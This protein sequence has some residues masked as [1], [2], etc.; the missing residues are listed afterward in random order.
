MQVRHVLRAANASL[1]VEIPPG[2]GRDLLAGRRPEVAFHIDGSS[3]FPGATVRTYVNATLLG[4]A[5]A[6][7]RALHGGPPANERRNAL[8]LQR[9][10]RSIYAITPGIIMLALI[11]IPTMLTALGVV[12]ERRWAP[13]PISTPRRQA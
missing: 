6:R 3:P 13:S 4:Y 10:V 8:R 2:F 12:R 5:Q 1:V 7:A 9:A 11:L